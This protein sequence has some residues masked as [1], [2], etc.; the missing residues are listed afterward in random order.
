MAQFAYEVMVKLFSEKG[1]R[2]SN[3]MAVYSF[4][5]LLFICFQKYVNVIYLGFVKVSSHMVYNI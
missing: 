2:F 5:K 1:E 4:I 3:I